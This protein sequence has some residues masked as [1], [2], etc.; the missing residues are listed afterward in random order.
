MKKTIILSILLSQFI[1]ASSITEDKEKNIVIYNNLGFVSE[2]KS[3]SINNGNSEI[4]YENVS[5]NIIED[6]VS[7][8]FPK[9]VFLQEQNFQYDTMNFNNILKYNLNKE[10]EYKD[11]INRN[12]FIIKKGK[13]LSFEPTIMIV[14][15]ESNKILNVY[16]DSIIIKDL[17][18]NM[19]IKPSL[20][21][22]LNSK[23]EI[24]NTDIKLS[25][26]TNNISWKTDYTAT[27]NNNLLNLNGWITINN[28]SDINYNGYNLTVLS[29]E[30]NKAE[31]YRPERIMMMKNS[32]SDASFGGNIVDKEISGYHIYKIPFKTD[33]PSLSKKQVSLL[34]NNIKNFNKINKIIINYIDGNQILNFDQFI[35]FKNNKDNGLGIPLP[36]GII[37]FYENQNNDNYFIGENNI[38]NVPNNENVSISI[39]K[40]FDSKLEIFMKERNLQKGNESLKYVMEIRNNSKT[41]Q[42]YNIIQKNPLSNFKLDNIDFKDFSSNGV[43]DFKI[44]NIDELEYN[45]ELE[46]ESKINIEMQV[47]RK[48]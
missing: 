22:K 47:K 15:N 29:G 34:N 1:Y 26:L 20:I 41:K 37:R 13:L 5:P 3:A 28:Q 48:Y 46:P 7:I 10:V 36:Y 4:K 6:S 16:N 40:N 27:I 17:P 23:K 33:I 42:K 12:E 31:I 14:D 43:Y 11:Y 38:G 25:Y 39:G 18:E 32:I 44:K 30:V 19:S 21:W 24:K 45:F 8:L 2:T 35:E 9:E